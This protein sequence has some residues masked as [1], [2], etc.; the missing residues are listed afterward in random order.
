MRFLS[1]AKKIQICPNCVHK[2]TASPK[3]KLPVQKI[4]QYVHVSADKSCVKLPLRG[5]C[6]KL[7]LPDGGFAAAIRPQG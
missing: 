7:R 2:K 5:V 6:G 3:S 4:C 1:R